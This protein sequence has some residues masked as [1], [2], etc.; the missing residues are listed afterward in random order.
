MMTTPIELHNG[1]YVKRD[2][3]FT[4]CGVAGG[5]ARSASF[6]IDLAGEMG[7]YHIVT[8]G[9]RFSPQVEIVGN[10]CRARGWGFTAFV[11]AGELSPDIEALMDFATIVKVPFGRNN[12]IKSH[13]QRYAYKNNA[14]LVPF[15]MECFEAVKQTASQVVDIPSEVKR[16]VIP[17][18]SAISLCG[19]LHGL[20]EVGSTLPVLG[21]SVGA[22]P[23]RVMKTYAPAGWESHCKI[24]R[25][26]ADY[27]T[28]VHA[29]LGSIT[30]DPVYEAKCLPFLQK[31][32]MLWVVGA[33]KSITVTNNIK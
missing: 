6:L 5:K 2:D 25:S 13:A 31:G 28:E 15:G 26:E 9:S 16:I 23:A 30:L 24:V 14:F 29:T 22:N 20:H 27:H 33:R 17:V 21:V 18:G 7:F 19:L 11:P 3:L 10:I 32:D 8:A 1:I 4:T 12:V